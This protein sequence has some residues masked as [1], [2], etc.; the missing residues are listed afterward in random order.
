[1]VPVGKSGSELVLKCRSCGF[2]S[3]TKPGEGYRSIIK[4]D[5]KSKV[6][7]TKM[8]SQSRKPT[9]VKEELEQAK[10]NYYELVLE[11]MGEYGE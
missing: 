1:M 4:A 2:E 3:K 10:E 9:S 5:K 6:Y 7:S 11:N 8:I